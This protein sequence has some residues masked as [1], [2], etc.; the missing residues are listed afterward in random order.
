MRNDKKGVGRYHAPELGVVEGDG[1]EDSPKL[2]CGRVDAP[3]NVPIAGKESLGDVA[4][5]NTQVAPAT[6]SVTESTVAGPQ[7]SN[8]R[9]V[10]PDKGDKIVGESTEGPKR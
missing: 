6:E 9:P 8:G 2:L 3:R 4:L 7:G 1:S 5:V 10:G